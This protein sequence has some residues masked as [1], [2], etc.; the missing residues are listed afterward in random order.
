M[1][2]ITKS[3]VVT[4]GLF[5]FVIVLGAQ[6]EQDMKTGA[7]CYLNVEL[8]GMKYKSYAEGFAN[9]K[10]WAADTFMDSIEAL[11]RDNATIKLEY[12]TIHCDAGGADGSP[13]PSNP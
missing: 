13:T 11:C 7:T 3:L 2:S 5:L 6:A 10:Q 12:G 9:G 8:N 4:L 1:V